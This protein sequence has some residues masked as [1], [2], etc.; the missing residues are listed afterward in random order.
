MSR[1]S[2]NR[3][4]PRDILHQEKVKIMRILNKT[5]RQSFHNLLAIWTANLIHYNAYR[6]NYHIY[7]VM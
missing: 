6:F 4:V 3:T 2:Y 5:S 1:Y 7:F